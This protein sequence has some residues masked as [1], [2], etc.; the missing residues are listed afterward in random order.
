M[1]SIAYKKNKPSRIKRIAKKPAILTRLVKRGAMI[2]EIRRNMALKNKKPLPHGAKIEILKLD[3][4]PHLLKSN[5]IISLGQHRLVSD[6]K[7][8]THPERFGGVFK[9][10]ERILYTHVESTDPKTIMKLSKFMTSQ[11]TSKILHAAGFAGLVGDTPTQTLI[12]MYLKLGFKES[13][14]SL[15]RLVK[16]RERLRYAKNIPLRGYPREF[17][18][19]PIRRVTFRFDEVL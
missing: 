6:A 4:A 5:V 18:N 17:I 11:E 14:D 19:S 3:S 13:T 7:T 2:S 10:G 15:P 12:K 8:I 1:Q 9:K 16:L